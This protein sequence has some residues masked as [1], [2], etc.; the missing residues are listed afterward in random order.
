MKQLTFIT[1]VFVFLAIILSSLLAF[2]YRLTVDRKEGF[3]QAYTDCRNK[4]FTSEFCV[5][6]P[7]GA[8]G[9]GTCLCDDGTIGLQLPGFGGDCVC[10]MALGNPMYR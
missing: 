5:Q 1:S 4:G 8:S 2:N 6:T 9:V 10:G 3:S 7:I